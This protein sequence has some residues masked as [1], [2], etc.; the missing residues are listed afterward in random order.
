M[1]KEETMAQARRSKG[2][3]A[4]GNHNAA[5]RRTARAIQ[6]EISSADL[7]HLAK[8][9]GDYQEVARKFADALESTKFRGTVSAQRLRGMVARGQRLGQRAAAVQL[10][11]MAADRRRMVQDSQAW[12][13]MLSNWRL[14][15]AAMP[16]RPEL[17]APFAFM[18]DYMSVT[19]STP[20][21]PAPAA[22]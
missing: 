7:K 12:K 9:P 8:A 10:K 2:D 11:A 14:V 18:Q 1:K 17:E 21:P 20:Q 22:P 15:I 5:K 4:N 16:D 3:A 19:R 13:S 6:V